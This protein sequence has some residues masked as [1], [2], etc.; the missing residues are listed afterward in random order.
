MRLFPGRVS[1]RSRSPKCRSR[2]AAERDQVR[3]FGSIALLLV[4][5]TISI[6][7]PAD[8]GWRSTL[9]AVIFFPVNE[10]SMNFA[11]QRVDHGYLEVLIVAEALVA[12]VPGNFSAILDCFCLCFELDPDSVSMGDAILHIEE[13]L[14]HCD[15]LCTPIRR[16]SNCS[17][18]T[19]PSSNP[20]GIIAGSLACVCTTGRPPPVASDG[21]WPRMP[22]SGDVSLLQAEHWGGMG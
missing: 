6:T 18:P 9:I 5:L 17:K 2:K 12:E 15:Y 8:K 7:A 22:R 10:L 14:L 11:P 3:V 1:R 21:W 20:I 13:E 4:G 19:A 16:V